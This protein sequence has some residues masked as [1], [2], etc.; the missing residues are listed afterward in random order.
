MGT[1]DDDALLREVQ[2]HP[3]VYDLERVYG[4]PAPDPTPDYINH[5]TVEFSDMCDMEPKPDESCDTCCF[6]P[7]GCTPLDRQGICDDY[8]QR[9]GLPAPTIT[10]DVEAARALRRMSVAVADAAYSRERTTTPHEAKDELLKDRAA[11]AA[12]RA[13][14]AAKDAEI[15][16]LSRAFDNLYAVRE[17]DFTAFTVERE[18]R[19]NAEAVSEAIETRRADYCAK[20]DSGPPTTPECY[21]S[22]CPLAFVMGNPKDSA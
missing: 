5:A 10:P 18:A 8:R 12:I 14:L 20:C 2:K 11:I 21:G 7:G 4:K 13:E 15:G 1:T 6:D 16:Q 3:G 17:R 22:G 19:E 9:P